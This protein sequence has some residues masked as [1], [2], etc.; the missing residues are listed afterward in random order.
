MDLFTLDDKFQRAQFVEGYESLIWSERYARSGDVEIKMVSTPENSALLPVGTALALS[1]SDRVMQIETLENKE[2]V[3][4]RKMLILKGPE[5]VDITTDRVTDSSTPGVG[6]N[7]WTATG[8]PGNI[9]RQLFSKVFVTGSLENALPFYTPGTLYPADTIAEPTTSYVIERENSSLYKAITELCDI[10]DLGFR[11]YKGPDTSKL[12]FNVYS[13]NNRTTSQ[14]V[15]PAVVFSP[16][17]DS[18][19]NMSE[20]TSIALSKNVA[21]VHGKNGVLTVY[22]ADTDPGV[23]GF[24]RRVL[25]VEAKDIDLAPGAALT[26]ALTQRGLLELAKNRS[27]SAFDGEISQYSM[28]RYRR[29]YYLGDLI[30]LRNDQ[31]LTNQMRVI[32]Q[33]FVSDAQGERA[34]P[35]LATKE[36]ITPGSWYAW[37]SNQVWDEALGVWADA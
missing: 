1:E 16:N 22:A 30:E 27:V 33:I 18:L 26:A 5:I 34:Y 8:T 28:Y 4:G 2:E 32:E 9:I 6:P 3:D 29:D 15:L 25:Y 17:L 20:F 13:G 10:W 37:K 24:A 11:L 21:E 23:S 35:T 36:F 7:T 14:S 19:Q 12:Y 31:G